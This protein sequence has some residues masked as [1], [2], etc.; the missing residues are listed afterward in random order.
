M[1]SE[2]CAKFSTPATPKIVVSPRE[3]RK[4]S[5][6]HERPFSRLTAR[7]STRVR[8]RPGARGERIGASEP[9]PRSLAERRHL[10]ARLGGGPRDVAALEVADGLEDADR[11]GLV[12]GG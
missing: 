6:P 12:R 11:I 3:M 8:P 5:I 1:K 10:A 7:T 4:S 9:R 2:P